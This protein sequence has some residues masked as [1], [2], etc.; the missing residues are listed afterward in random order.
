MASQD[1]SNK[2]SSKNKHTISNTVECSKTDQSITDT[3]VE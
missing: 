3:K 1:Q 2:E